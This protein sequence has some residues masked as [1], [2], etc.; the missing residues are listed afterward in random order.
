M[1]QTTNYV[2]CLSLLYNFKCLEKGFD[3]AL[4]PNNESVNQIRKGTSWNTPLPLPV[5]SQFAN[6]STDRR[7]NIQT[8]RLMSKKNSI[9]NILESN[10]EIRDLIAS[11]WSIEP[12]NRPKFKDINTFLRQKISSFNVEEEYHNIQTTGRRI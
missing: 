8:P 12:S 11:C 4:L 3:N 10:R 6:I 9:S 2:K 5:P 7:G 1:D